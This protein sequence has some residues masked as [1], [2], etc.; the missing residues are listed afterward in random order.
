LNKNCECE[1]GSDLSSRSEAGI[2]L[3][4]FKPK[5]EKKMRPQQNR[6]MRGRSNNN[7]GNRNRMPNPLTRNYESN[8]PDVKIRGNAQHIADKYTTLARDAQASGDRIMA[9]NYL[10]HAEHYVR[11]ILSAQPQVVQNLRDDTAYEEQSSNNVV[12]LPVVNAGDTQEEAQGEEQPLTVTQ[13]VHDMD[14]DSRGN[15][16]EV[17]SGDANVV[18]AAEKPQTDRPRR[19]T[20]RRLPRQIAVEVENAEPIAQNAEDEGKKI[21]R[22]KSIK[23]VVAVMPEEVK[24]PAVL[25]ASRAPSDETVEKPRRRRRVL[26]SEEMIVEAS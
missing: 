10:Q 7:N 26:K 2:A 9:E 3:K 19:I 1:N 15:D 20:R 6:R 23:P 8:G 11:I 12:D 18:R 4:Y 5:K 21:R 25:E 17:A 22:P 16:M 24:A 13:D 14:A